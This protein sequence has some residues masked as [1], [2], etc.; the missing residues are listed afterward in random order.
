VRNALIVLAVVALVIVLAGA[1]NHA[2]A[3]DIDFVAGTVTGVSLAWVA[4]AVAGVG[5]VAGAVAIWLTQVSS[6]ST[7]RKLE[8]ELQT[9]YERLREVEALAAAKNVALEA[10]QAT[11]PEPAGGTGAATVVAHEA[12]TSAHEATVAEDEATVS[13]TEGALAGDDSEQ[14]SVTAVAA[15]DAGDGEEQTAEQT[16]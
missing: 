14:T 7:R 15:A 11:R 9:T 12:T 16:D 13:T 4:V 8:A 6:A 3:F 1:L 10:R 5:F 2:V